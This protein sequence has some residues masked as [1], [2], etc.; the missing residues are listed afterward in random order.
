MMKRILS[1]AAVIGLAV[2]WATPG[3][4]QMWQDK[5]NAT[6]A[7]AKTQK[8]ILT[9]HGN[10]A[11]PE[12][13]KAFEKKYGIEVE[14]SAQR[15]SR[16]LARIRTEQKN[17]QYLWDIW[18]AAT[19]N[20]T[21]IAAPAGMMEPL[22]DVLILPE[23]ADMSNWRD[24]KY[25]FGDKGHNVFTFRNYVTRSVF[26]NVNVAKGVKI[27]SFDDFLNPALRGKIAIRDSSRPNAAAFVLALMQDRKGADFV[28][29]FLTEMRPTIYESPKQIF[30]AV[31]RG[32]AG[33]AIGARETEYSR[34]V[35]DGGCK[36]II[37]PDGFEYILSWG[38][39]IFKNA[40]H[41]EAATIWVNWL[42]SKEGQQVMV[43][44]WAK[45]NIDGAVSMRKDVAPAKDHE[46]SL[47]DFSRPHEYMWVAH[48]KEGAKIKAA[49]ATY[50]AVK[51]E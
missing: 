33:L 6:L 1:A 10:D 32:G 24:P 38:V 36:N 14:V 43:E 44:K 31:V 42:L 3:S 7:K 30:N 35:L 34:C 2:A 40:P 48:D 21:N 45:H 50:R 17:G 25:V 5:W 9:Q 37:E 26:R 51:A 19:S 12:V 16:A 20:M 41:K 46:K 4:A 8:L 11:I 27:R 28:K 15:P 18:L 39:A 47:P 23:V 13:V 22:D 49:V 29:R